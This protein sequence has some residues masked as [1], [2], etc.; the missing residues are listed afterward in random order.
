MP[1]APLVHWPTVTN[2]Q[3]TVLLVLALAAA[4]V[5]VVLTT[6]GGD[7][8]AAV[9]ST[10]G[11]VA[12]RTVTTPSTAATTTS[13]TTT[14]KA[15]ETVIR[16][17][18][19]KPVGGLEKIDVR[20]GETVRLEVTSKDTSEEVHVHG[21]DLLRDLA[22]GQPARFRFEADIEGIFEIELEQSATQLAELRVQ[23]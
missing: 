2:V 17:A 7:D 9:S 11:G 10:A 23:P 6:T 15:P 12:E 16:V 20:R 22:P 5:A 18:G 3:R 14:P 1:A 13:T 21:Y 19:G 4:A 8:E